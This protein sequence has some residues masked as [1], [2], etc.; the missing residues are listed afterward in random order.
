MPQCWPLNCHQ[1]ESVVAKSP[2][3]L[4]AILHTSLPVTCPL[5]LQALH[6]TPHQPS[7]GQRDHPLGPHV[8]WPRSL[9]LYPGPPSWIPQQLASRHTLLHRESF[10][11]FRSLHC[12][13]LL[14]PSPAELAFKGCACGARP[15]WLYSPTWDFKSSKSATTV[16]P[17]AFD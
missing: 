17:S 2:Y 3:L 11:L 13:P 9:T 7:P 4:A 6:N 14:L 12:P 8:I 15:A 10:P 1:L 16:P 5:C